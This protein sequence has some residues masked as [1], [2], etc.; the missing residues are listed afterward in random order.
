MDAPVAS[1]T[2]AFEGWRFDPRAGGLLRRDATGAWTPVSIGA[3]AR[4][5]LEFLL[6][7]AG[8]LVSKDAIMDAA[9]PNVVV[10]RTT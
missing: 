8:A 3:R 7:Q 1:E 5:I 6:E 9:W 4:D 2:L 10:D